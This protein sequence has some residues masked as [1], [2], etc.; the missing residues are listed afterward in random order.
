VPFAHVGSQDIRNGYFFEAHGEFGLKG[1]IGFDIAAF[2]TWELFRGTCLMN[3]E[4]R[5][6]SP[7]LTAATV[8]QPIKLYRRRQGGYSFFASALIPDR[9]SGTDWQQLALLEFSGGI[10]SWQC[11]EI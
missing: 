1:S 5:D 4:R 7:S 10:I 9:D 2:L 8:V 3:L 11:Y 6:A